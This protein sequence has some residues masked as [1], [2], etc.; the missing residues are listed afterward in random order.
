[1][2]FADG[3]EAICLCSNDYLGLADDPAVVAA[4]ATGLERYGAG[5]ASVRFICGLFTPH[6]ELERDIAEFLG[7]DAAITY[8]SCWNANQALLDTLS[9]E[10]TWILSDELN[11]ASIID[12]IRL[13]AARRQGGLRARRPQRLAEA[14]G[15]VPDGARCLIVTDGVFSMEGDLAPL[16]GIVDLAAEHGASVIVD[17]SHGL[18]VL[19]ASGA[20][21]P[22]TSASRIAS[23]S[24]PARWARRSAER[25]ES[26]VAGGRALCDLL[27]QRSRPALLQR[28]AAVGRLRCA[29][30]ARDPAGRALR[31]E[32]LHENVARF[33]AGVTAAGLSALEGER[34]RPDRRRRDPRRHRDERAPLRRGRLRDR[35]RLPRR[36]RGNG[37]G[38]RSDLSRARRQRRSTPR[39]RRS[40]G[41]PTNPHPA[42]RTEVGA[43]GTR[44]VR[45]SY[46]WGGATPR[47]H[48]SE[49]A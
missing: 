25:R 1:M 38:P 34:H 7:T 48:R 43:M 26:F 9:G 14:L 3:T 23:T 28:P 29:R 5:T 8:T 40:S 36:P 44:F 37:T 11:H 24:S 10:R 15:R 39:W 45:S 13:R 35:L 17:D 30:R 2:R 12:G 41:S 42:E 47:S 46:S 22:S 4:A 32:Q 31:L 18:G 16:P 21:P 20:A 19:G 27:E 49:G 6:L 33:R